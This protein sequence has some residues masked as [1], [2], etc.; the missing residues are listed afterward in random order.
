M[1]PLQIAQTK[2]ALGLVGRTRDVVPFFYCAADEDGQPL[3]IA[4]PERLDRAGVRAIVRRA[5][6]KVF[7][8]GQVERAEDG[9]L[10]FCVP[11]DAHIERFVIDLGRMDPLVPGLR[12]A[13]VRV[14]D[15]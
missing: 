13:Q 2:Q 4:Q 8:R 9:G 10:Q 7:I 6:E 15:G 12:L 3:L 1:D 11:G 5:R 14:V